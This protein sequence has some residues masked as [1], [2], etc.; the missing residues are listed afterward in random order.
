LLKK[1]FYFVSSFVIILLLTLVMSSNKKNVPL[2]HQAVSS[3]QTSFVEIN[4]SS[5]GDGAIVNVNQAVN[6]NHFKQ[7]F[8][9]YSFVALLA[10]F[11]IF[12]VNYRYFKSKVL[13]PPWYIIFKSSSRIS[14]S[15]WKVSN[16]LYK[17][18][19]LYQF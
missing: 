16:L 17:S 2:L 10:I 3:V 6:F 5:D 13:P 4:K 8:V 7:R 15:G 11:F 19:L 18:K 1:S 9:D 14:L 12:V